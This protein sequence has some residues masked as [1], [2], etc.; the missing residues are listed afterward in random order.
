MLEYLRK[1]LLIPGQ[2]EN[3]IILMDLDKLG[4]NEIPFAV[5][6]NKFN[7]QALGKF[8]ENL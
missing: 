3:W 6:N 4:L 1:H 2:V 8:L 5:I 7:F